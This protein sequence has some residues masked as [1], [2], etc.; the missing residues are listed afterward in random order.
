MTGFYVSRCCPTSSDLRPLRPLS[1]TASVNGS[2]IFSF[3]IE[4]AVLRLELHDCE[5][6]DR[7]EV[8]NVGRRHALAE[9][10]CRHTDEQTRQWQPHPSGLILAVDFSGT[11][12]YRRCNKM[13]R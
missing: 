7:L 5:A 4:R 11:N 10:K 12:R 13:D 8:A 2:K 1:S 6:G 3:V 9:F